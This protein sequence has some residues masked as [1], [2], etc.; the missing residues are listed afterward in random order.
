MILLDTSTILFWTFAPEKLS[1]P[2]VAAME[3]NATLLINAISLWEIG[4][5]IRQGKLSLPMDIHDYASHLKEADW[6]EIQS[7][8]LKI[9]LHSIDLDWAHRDPADRIIV[10]AA[11][12]LGC[13]LISSDRRIRE[14]YPLA[15]W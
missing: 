7:T 12:L 13:P 11:D 5:K 14:F 9:W 2:A 1:K 15:I 8:D 4:W 3:E 10:A 6:V